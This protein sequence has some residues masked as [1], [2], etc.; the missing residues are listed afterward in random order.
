MPKIPLSYRVVELA[1]ARRGTHSILDVYWSN[2]N[3]YALLGAV[4][5]RLPG[6]LPRA[7][8]E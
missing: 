4:V 1:P 2:H 7:R 3:I 6:I 8:G 5:Y